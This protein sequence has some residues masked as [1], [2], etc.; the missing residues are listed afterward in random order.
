[1]A[2]PGDGAQAAGAPDRR[3]P[4]ILRRHPISRSAALQPDS[5][6]VVRKRGLQRDGT[7][8]R[9]LSGRGR[10]RGRGSDGA[11]T[12]NEREA[13]L[14]ELNLWPLWRRKGAAPAGS[15]TGDARAAGIL[16]MDWEVL[17]RSVAACTAC[18]LH[19]TRSQAVFGVG[20]PH[21]EWLFVGEAPGAEEDARGEPFVGQAGRLLDSMLAGIGLKRGVD[22]YI[23]NVLKCRPPGNRNPEPS[24]VAQ[25]A[26]HL[27]R[28]V[29]LIQPR[30]IL[31]MGRFA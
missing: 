2:A 22:V 4:G 5:L 9:L 23:A 18:P 19:R 1:M 7:A 20:D 13:Y 10:A 6:P 12:V 27:M 26:P 21:A 25:C 8:P 16:G 3:G 31:A 28:Q 17:Q 29:E 30:L 15:G 14:K 24:E 11:G